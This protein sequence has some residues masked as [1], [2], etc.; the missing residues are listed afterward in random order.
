MKSIAFFDFDKTVY[1]KDSMLVFMKTVNGNFVLILSLIRV[2]PLFLLSKLKLYPLKKTKEKLL[3]VHFK[4]KKPE[5]LDPIQADFCNTL[6]MGIYPAAKAKLMQHK[7]LG[8]ELCVVSASCD[9]WL[10]EWCKK[11]GV[12]L[13]CSQMEISENNRYT[14]KLKGENC[15]GREKVVQIKKHYQLSDYKQIYVYGRGSGDYEMLTLA[16]QP[17]EQIYN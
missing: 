15:R 5:D 13:I 3:A 9:L 1:R 12:D 11:E 8:H 6:D 2:F 14:G 17:F 7:Q 10:K 4:G 16:N